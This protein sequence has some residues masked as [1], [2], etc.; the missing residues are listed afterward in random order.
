VPSRQ[1]PTTVLVGAAVAVTL[2]GSRRMLRNWGATKAETHTVFTGDELV[3]DPAV[4]ITRAVTIEASTDE[5]WRWLVQVGQDRGGMYSYD[6]LENLA[7]LRIH[8]T[9]W[10]RPEWQKLDVG[11]EI[12]LVRPGWLGMRDGYVLRV[13]ALETGSSLVLMDDNW[14]SVWSFHLRAL[15]WNRC[16]L[17]S[18]SRSPQFGNALAVVSETLDPLTFV[19]TRG[20][21]LGIK[22][23]AEASYRAVW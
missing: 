23:R 22:R 21:L 17:I 10:I 9:E 12:R 8:S 20:M 4:T 7:G 15:G 16:R 1:V 13:A 11:D 19:M 14:H 6:F 18:R 2:I 3:P 5:V